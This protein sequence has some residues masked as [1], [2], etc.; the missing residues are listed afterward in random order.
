[1]RTTRSPVNPKAFD[2]YL[3]G[4]YVWNNTVTDEDFQKAAAY[5]KEA[6]AIDPDSAFAH[7]AL[8]NNFIRRGI[9]EYGL[10]AP[11][12]VMP[13]A[14]KAALKALVI[15]NTPPRLICHWRW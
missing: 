15:D 10:V 4:R 3:K 13:K 7:A 8:A 5:Y 11:R 6:I 1:M 14:R 12:D 9:G 2:L